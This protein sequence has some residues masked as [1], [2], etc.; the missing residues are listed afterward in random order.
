MKLAESTSQS[1]ELTEWLR[2][3]HSPVLLAHSIGSPVMAKNKGLGANC[4]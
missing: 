2:T 1:R 4:G 3:M